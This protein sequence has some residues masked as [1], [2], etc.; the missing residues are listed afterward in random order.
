MAHGASGK[1]STADQMTQINLDQLTTHFIYTHP[2]HA[3]E[4]E[5]HS[6]APSRG[7]SQITAGT[8]SQTTT[9]TY[10]HT[11]PAPNGSSQHATKLLVSRPHKSKSS[12]APGISRIPCSYKNNKFHVQSPTQRRFSRWSHG[13]FIASGF[14]T[15]A[16]R[17]PT[18]VEG[19]AD[20]TRIGPRVTPTG[21]VAPESGT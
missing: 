20:L 11:V 1:A 14:P 17:A 19:D 18:P 5:D 6:D 10:R 4:E 8:S 9:R 12:I 15:E 3:P 2:D 21:V 16:V 13:E 7:H